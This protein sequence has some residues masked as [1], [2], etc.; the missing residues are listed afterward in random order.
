MFRGDTTVEMS[1]SE[2][3][4]FAMEN[5]MIDMNTIQTQI[6][7]KTTKEYLEQHTYSIW[8]GNDGY[9]HTYLPN[10]DGTRKP[11]KKK[12]EK[13]IK[14]T[15]V[16]YWKDKY[17]NTFKERYKTWIE[18]QEA[19][20]RSGNTIY[21]YE[22]DYERFFAGDLFENMDIRDITEVEISEFIKRLLKRKPIPYKALKAMYGYLKGVFRKAI[23]DK[24]IKNDDPCQYVDLPYYKQYCTEPNKKTAAQRTFSNSERKSVLNKVETKE[25]VVRYAVGLAMFTGMRVGEL[26]ALKW[27]HVD[28]NAKHILVCASEKS[29][30]KTGE[31]KISTTKNDKI[32][33]IPLTDDMKEILDKVKRLEVKNGWLTEFIFSNETG[34][35]RARTISDCARNLT[36]TAEFS[37]SKSIHAARRTLNSNM[38]CDGVSEVV[39]AAILGNTERVNTE[40]YTYDVTTNDY[41]YDVMTKAG[42]IG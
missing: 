34:R 39:T 42:K 13:D 17:N 35:V 10:S 36:M 30:R 37:N 15:V 6:E 7:M 11:I 40:H 28:Y 12:S 1:V 26:A 19:C 2:M 31:V 4:K 9:W 23:V 29:D 32:R 27:E 24:V 22:K 41:K 8:K 3:L 20:G 5:G 14:E 38:R 25:T 16:Q 18:R 21:K 33:K